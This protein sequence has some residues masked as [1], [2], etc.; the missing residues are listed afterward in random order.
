MKILTVISLLAA[1]LSTHL[2]CLAVSGLFPLP[3]NGCPYKAPCYNDRYEFVDIKQFSS[4]KEN[5]GDWN[6]NIH[7]N[8]W[9]YDNILNHTLDSLNVIN[10]EPDSLTIFIDDNDIVSSGQ[11]TAIRSNSAAF[12]I[13]ID[14]HKIPKVTPLKEYIDSTEGVVL[15]MEVSNLYCT[16]LS[17]DMGQIQNLLRFST[18]PYYNRTYKSYH[19]IIKDHKIIHIE[20]LLF[21]EA[22]IWRLR[23]EDFPGQE[24]VEEW[25]ETCIKQ[26]YLYK[27]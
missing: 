7:H 3:T 5:F 1:V 2:D 10:W 9:G 13:Y 21:P 18:P 16:I 23:A 17:W 14:I 20:G 6:P 27:R 11:Y 26:R 24:K 25:R 4:P 19:I 15:K 12:M 8:S 22:N